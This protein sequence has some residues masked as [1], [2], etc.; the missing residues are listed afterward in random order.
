[1]AL[2]SH[3]PSSVSRRYFLQS[4]LAGAGTLL[5]TRPGK[6]WAWANATQ[7][8]PYHGFHMGLQSYSLRNFDTAEALEMTKKLGLHYWEAFRNHIPISTVPGYIAEQ[9]EKLQQA[10]V[11]LVA[12][13]VVRFDDNETKAREIFDFAKAMGLWS[14]SADPNPDDATMSLL[15]KLV[16]E[17]QIP[18]AIHN[19]GPGHRY[20]KVSDVLKVVNDRHPLLGACVDTGHYLRSDEDPVAVIQQL[21]KRVFGVHFK[22]VRTIRSPEEKEKLL[23]EL[24]KNRANQLNREGKVF[25][26]LGEGEL[27]VV[28][29]LRA[30][31]DLEYERTLSLE[32]EENPENPLSDIELSLAAVRKAVAYLDDPEDDFI[33]LWDGKT[34]DNWKINEHPE[35]WTIKDGTI[36]CNGPR[37]HLFY[38]GD[39]APFK[40]FQLKVDV[41]A[42][43]NSNAGIYFHTRYQ[44]EGWPAKGFETQ[45]N[46]SYHKDPRKT[47][48]LYS[49]D[50]VL[51]QYI[52]DNTWWT[53]DI[54]VRGNHVVIKIDGRTVTDYTQ[55]ENVASSDKKFERKFDSGTFALQGHDPG[56]TVA[57]K[58]IRVRRLPD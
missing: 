28:G 19:H 8:D 32:Y 34:F 1:M 16:E 15:E 39:E 21:G 29:V 44:D 10:G 14:I 46:N 45:V 5:L 42:A 7:S 3:R 36:V 26:I 11:Q 2:D 27:N 33:S 20:D 25:T 55:P 37:S 18:I 57:F 47:G 52:P 35:T 51:E 12:Y 38:M 4:A 53:Q 6:T 48:S 58:N 23:K 22:D 24:P 40:N 30:L 50:D 13:G 43:P 31:R 9:K 54:T 41:K 49:V 56:S 17:Y